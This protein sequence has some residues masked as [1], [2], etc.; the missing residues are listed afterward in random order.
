[1]SAASIYVYYR[2]VPAGLE[3]FACLARLHLAVVAPRFEARWRL[4]RS[5]TEPST[6]ME[7]LDNVQDTEAAIDA[8]RANWE[9][10]GLRRFLAPGSERHIE[11]FEDTESC[12]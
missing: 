12:A 9:I 8:L 5:R 10:S 7:V 4:M 3:D 1:M 11:V 2:I 6:W